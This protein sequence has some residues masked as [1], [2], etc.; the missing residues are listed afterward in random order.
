MGA[1]MLKLIPINGPVSNPSDWNPFCAEATTLGAG[2]YSWIVSDVITE[3]SDTAF[4]LADFNSTVADATLFGL[5]PSIGL[6]LHAERYSRSTP[7]TAV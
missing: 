3:E 4:P 5:D 1:V 6:S 7:K 2:R